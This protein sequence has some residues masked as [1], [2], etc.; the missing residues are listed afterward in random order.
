M[1]DNSRNRTIIQAP[2]TQGAAGQLDLVAAQAGCRIY[3]TGIYLAA[4]G[5]ATVT[6]Q[7]GTGPTNLTGALPLVAGVPVAEF[8]GSESE[9][10]LATNTAGAKL[11]LTSV[12]LPV[13]GWIR[14]FVAA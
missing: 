14:Y 8:S 6:L 1:P 11:S 13:F 9:P 4:T 3:V 10:I 7:E 12:T 5:A 2:I